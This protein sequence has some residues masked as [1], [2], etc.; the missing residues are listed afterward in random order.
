M[1]E[2]LKKKLHATE[3]FDYIF[4][5]CFCI[6]WYR[7]RTNITRSEQSINYTSFAIVIAFQLHSTESTLEHLYGTETHGIHTE[8][9]FSF[10]VYIK[11]IQ[12][13]KLMQLFRLLS[14]IT[15]TLFLSPSFFKPLTI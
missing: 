14:F 9:P 2:K 6:F 1:K 5:R 3:C 10:I 12:K 13:Y 7:I 15:N 11:P 4:I 8:Y